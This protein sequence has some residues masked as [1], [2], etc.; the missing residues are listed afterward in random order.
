MTDQQNKTAEI[1]EDPLGNETQTPPAQP[2]EIAPAPAQAAPQQ[3]YIQQPQP[4]ANPLADQLLPYDEPVKS[5]F[6][7]IGVPFLIIFLSIAIGYGIYISLVVNNKATIVPNAELY[8]NAK[9]T[10]ETTT[11]TSTTPI[12]SISTTPATPKPSLALPKTPEEPI[13]VNR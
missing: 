3:Q 6:L 9:Q 10:Q 12:P 2:Q 4:G 8:D 5:P 11:S 1:Q 13:K 7:I